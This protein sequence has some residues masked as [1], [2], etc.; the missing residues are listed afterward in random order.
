[1]LAT[2]LRNPGP[3]VRGASSELVTLKAQID[4]ETRE[5]E[6]PASSLETYET[7]RRLKAI[8]AAYKRLHRKFFIRTPCKLHLQTH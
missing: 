7:L 3:E 4:G 6:L 2:L 1:M 8:K 5:I